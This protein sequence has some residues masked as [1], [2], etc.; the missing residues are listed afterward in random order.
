MR[1]EK[2][3]L[4][5]AAA[6]GQSAE[7]N[8][9]AERCHEHS[10]GE[11]PEALPQ[12]E[13]SVSCQASEST[14]QLADSEPFHGGDSVDKE[15]SFLFPSRE[16]AT[17]DCSSTSSQDENQVQVPTPA[18]GVGRRD[19][20]FS[21]D[22][23]ED[24]DSPIFQ[25]DK[26]QGVSSR[27]KQEEA[28]LR[29]VDGG[30]TGEPLSSGR[31][32]GC[33]RDASGV[34]S[35]SSDAESL[36]VRGKQLARTR[37]RRAR[38]SGGAGGSA[39]P[40]TLTRTETALFSD[41][42]DSRTSAVDSGNTFAGRL[43]EEVRCM[44]PERTRMSHCEEAE[45]TGCCFVFASGAVVIWGGDAV[46][47]TEMKRELLSNLMWFLGRFASRHNK[48]SRR[49]MAVPGFRCCRAPH[50]TSDNLICR[51]D[52]GTEDTHVGARMFE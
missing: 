47:G 2:A 11:A 43:S 17:D 29:L 45:R 32:S 44:A 26:K 22:G 19:R 23:V 18:N 27:R 51:G 15:L 13:A 5:S 9:K 24:M 42:D 38:L 4:Q 49:H 21:F 12:K 50:P 1:K 20:S 30:A 16:L 41:K 31:S 7:G 40:N 37:K 34:L 46:G 48:S 39:A 36:A 6:C 52:N 35:L 10:G 28:Y 25:E 8:G 14:S 33:E 3:V